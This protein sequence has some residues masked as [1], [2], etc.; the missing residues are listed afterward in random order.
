M[1]FQIVRNDI[2]LMDVDAIVN[3]ANPQPMIGYGVDAGIHQK[4]GPRLL[5]ARRRIG[6]IRVGDAAIT[7]GFDLPAKLVFIRAERFLLF[8]AVGTELCLCG[9]L[10]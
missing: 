3:T 8:P 7:P 4:A 5:E 2:T 9:K 6:R 1:P 10:L